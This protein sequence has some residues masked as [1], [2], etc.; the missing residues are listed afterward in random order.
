MLRNTSS[1]LHIYSQA[2]YVQVWWLSQV[3][4]ST[5]A[6]IYI[7]KVRSRSMLSSLDSLV[8]HAHLAKIDLAIWLLYFA[9]QHLPFSNAEQHDV[10]TCSALQDVWHK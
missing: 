2:A 7:V 4:I 9:R 8:Q 6:V 5:S 3:V 10:A 1:S